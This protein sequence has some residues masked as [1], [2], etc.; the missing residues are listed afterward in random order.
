LAAGTVAELAYHSSVFGREK[1]KF[2]L[3]DR[4]NLRLIISNGNVSQR[5]LFPGTYYILFNNF[6]MAEKAYFNSLFL[7]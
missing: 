3:T 6:T 5:L 4:K 2:F 1:Y 7:F